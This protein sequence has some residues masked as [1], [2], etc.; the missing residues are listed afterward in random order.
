M[1]PAMLE[2]AGIKSSSE[3]ILYNAIL[4]TFSY[5]SGAF[6]ALFI[7]GRFGR[8]KIFITTS[9]IFCIQFIIITALTAT[10]SEPQYKDNPNTS[11]SKATMAFIFLFRL[12]YS[13]TF[14][15]LHPVYPVECF[16]FEI[17]AK[18]EGFFTIADNIASFFNTYVTPI[19]LKHASE[20]H[21]S[22]RHTD[23]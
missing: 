2:Q 19:G 10:F 16:S 5:P 4:N 21:R 3:Q 8:R 20:W 11:A 17:R 18:G 14:T 12:T 7:A 9:Y 13:L 6:A 1:Y 15:P 22:S 23:C